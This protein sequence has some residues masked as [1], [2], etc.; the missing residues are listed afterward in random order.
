MGFMQPDSK[1]TNAVIPSE[2]SESRDLPKHRLAYGQKIP[3]CASLSRDD[4]VSSFFDGFAS[5][6]PQP[7]PQ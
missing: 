2:Q 3:P 4:S 7:K 5:C 1:I 6:N